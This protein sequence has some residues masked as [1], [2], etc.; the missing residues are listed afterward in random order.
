MEFWEGK[1]ECKHKIVGSENAVKLKW[2]IIYRFLYFQ[3]ILFLFGL[4]R[5]R[6]G[7]IHSRIFIIYFLQYKII[8]LKFI[9][10]LILFLSQSCTIANLFIKPIS[11]DLRT[12]FAKDLTKLLLNF[13][14]LKEDLSSCFRDYQKKKVIIS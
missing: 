1:I 14:F 10:F 12:S 6:V 13:A 2:F 9:H 5:I 7:V 3:M 11:N 4:K 8:Y